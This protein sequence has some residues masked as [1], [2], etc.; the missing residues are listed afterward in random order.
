GPDA[1]D[2][3]EDPAWLDDFL[4]AVSACV[5]PDSSMGPL[6]L[7]YQEEEGFWEVQI[8]P[9]PVEVVG[10]A[11]DGELVAPGFSL[12]LEELRSTFDSITDLGWNA[13]ELDY[14]EGPHI[15]IEGRFQGHEVYLEVLAYAPDDEEPG[16]KFDAN[17]RPVP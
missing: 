5:E 15:Y 2:D 1:G 12:N 11:H 3:S 13:L 10:G 8:Y 17:K 6:G 9:T 16:M 14:P 4:Q 7:R